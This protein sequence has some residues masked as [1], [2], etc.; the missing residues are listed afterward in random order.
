M[1][2]FVRLTVW[3]RSIHLKI[4]EINWMSRIPRL[5]HQTLQ[6]EDPGPLT[7]HLVLRYWGN[8]YVHS[9]APG[10]FPAEGTVVAQQGDDRGGGGGGRGAKRQG[11]I[12]RPF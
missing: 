6:L 12:L 10:W 4:W 8:C 3:L 7:R 9:L 1:P 2:G 11:V 5:L